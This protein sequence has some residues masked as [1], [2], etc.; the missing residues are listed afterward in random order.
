MYIIYCIVLFSGIITSWDDMEKLWHQTF[1]GEIRMAPEDHPILLTEI[2]NNPK[3]NREKM[4][5]IMFETFQAPAF[6]IGVQGVL[7]M[8]AS[9]RT[10]G[11][12]FESG[13]GVSHVVPVYEGCSIPDAIKKIDLAGGDIT[14][15]LA[16]LLTEQGFEFSDSTQME[17]VREIKEKL[18]YITINFDDELAKCSESSELQKSYDLPDGRVITVGNERFRCGEVIFKPHHIG[19]EVRNIQEV[20]FSA[21]QKCNIDIRNALYSNIV[22]S[23]G[24]TM[25]PGL[26]ERLKKEVS[27]MLPLAH[28]KTMVNV[29]SQPNRSHLAWKGGSV[30]A[31]MPNFQNMWILK[32]Q[33]EECGETIVHRKCV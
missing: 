30:L 7:A 5:Q 8:Y 15:Y 33:Y 14:N 1:Y 9:G 21:V 17:V 24:C 19:S 29:I 20:L 32:Q 6:Y 10:T 12:V 22:L 3:P 28:E 11:V 18:S 26:A 13:D 31:S 2:P 16:R 23:G 25:F 27:A 4:T